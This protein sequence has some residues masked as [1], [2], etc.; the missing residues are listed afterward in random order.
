MT[1]AS[2]T[3]SRDGSIVKV[4]VDKGVIDYPESLPFW[5]WLFSSNQRH[6]QQQQRQQISSPHLTQDLYRC[7]ETHKPWCLSE[8]KKRADASSRLLLS[9]HDN[10]HEHDG[11][12]PFNELVGNVA[13]GDDSADDAGELPEYPVSV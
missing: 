13:A 1:P 7:L 10:G 12:S 3:A 2:D 8:V 11:V 4:L 5:Q 9:S 6:Q